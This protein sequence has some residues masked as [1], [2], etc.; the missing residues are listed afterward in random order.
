MPK[1]KD[2]YEAQQWYTKHLNV[3]VVMEGQ[4]R[5]IHQRIGILLFDEGKTWKEIKEIIFVEF[6]DSAL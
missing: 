1:A 6:G 5:K 3:L 4:I 2:L